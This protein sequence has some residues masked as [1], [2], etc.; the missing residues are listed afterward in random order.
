MQDG[1]SALM[2]AASVG[3][4]DSVQALIEA[5][6]DTSVASKVHNLILKLKSIHSFV[7][8]FECIGIG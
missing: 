1:Y 4:A 5:G 2:W 6:A 8:G 3:S 7:N